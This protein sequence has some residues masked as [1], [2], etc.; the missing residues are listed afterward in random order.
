MTA[1]RFTNMPELAQVIGSTC[2]KKN[3]IGSLIRYIK[4]NNMISNERKMKKERSYQYNLSY[5]SMLQLINKTAD[6]KESYL[7][8]SPGCI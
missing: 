7:Y 6:K 3:V 4:N 8:M 2:F 1:L 5:F